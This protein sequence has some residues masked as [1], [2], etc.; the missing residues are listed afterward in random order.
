M[1]ATPRYGVAAYALPYFRLRAWRRDPLLTL[2]LPTPGR[3]RILLLAPGKKQAQGCAGPRAYRFRAIAIARHNA[4][5]GLFR[6]AGSMSP[7]RRAPNQRKRYAGLSWGERGD[8]WGKMISGMEQYGIKQRWTVHPPQS[9][10][11]DGTR[12]MKAIGFIR[13][14]DALLQAPC[15]YADAVRG[16]ISG[17][18]DARP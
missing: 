8:R 1:F 2:A 9:W 6:H 11:L 15:G 18:H 4:R 17:G 3:P 5:L 10:A 12:G 7:W 16:P 13:A 14:C